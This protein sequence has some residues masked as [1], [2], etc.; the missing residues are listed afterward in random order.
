M[1]FL[2]PLGL[3][4]LLGIP[5]LIIIYI[6]K[7]KYTE[8]TIASTYLWT[9]SEKFIKKKNPISRVTGII[10]LIL[11][12]LA[13][14]LISFMVAQPIINVPNSANE[15]CF[16]L[17]GSG[18]MNME[19]GGKTRFERGQ[20]IIAGEIDASANGSLYSLVYMGDT[21]TVVY[22]KLESKEAAKELL[23]ELEPSYKFIE[24]D[25]AISIAQSF[26]NENTGIKSYFV[27]DK[28]YRTSN[29][30]IIKN[31]ARDE[32]NNAIISASYALTKDENGS[33]SSLVVTGVAKSYEGRVPLTFNVYVDGSEEIR[34]SWQ[35]LVEEKE[36]PFTVVCEGISSVTS[37][38]VRVSEYDNLISD[39]SYVIFNQKSEV[40]YSTLIVSDN[41]FYIRAAIEALYDMT[42]NVVS[43]DEYENMYNDKLPTGYGLYI[44][45]SYNVRELPRD[46]AVWLF[47]LDSAPQG[48]GFS[49]QGKVELA[50]G[51]ALDMSKSSASTIK[52]LT[53]GVIG[54]DLYI[55]REFMKYGV[56]RSSHTLFS[57]KGNPIVFAGVN[58][59]GN[60]QVVF[61]FDYH[62]SNFP[63]KPGDYLMLNKN[64]IDYSFPEI[65]DKSGYRCGES[66]E[67]NVLANCDSIRIDSPN[68][69]V[70][71]LD[72]GSATASLE[73]TEVG[74]YTIT[75]QIG[76][77]KRVVNIFSSMDERESVPK[78]LENEVS[79]NGQASS[80][81][82]DGKFD[83]IIILFILLAIVF[84]A[85]W[86]VYC[87]ERCQLR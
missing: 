86:M 73:L 5:I 33:G 56:Y 59:Y 31:V 10:S 53:S 24:A 40:A 34:G 19:T 66:V 20:D 26:F 60:R 9:L 68:E 42:I 52:K 84:L 8:Q 11:Q 77:T 71:Y 72:T 32:K 81:G 75:M 39:N 46:G 65:I 27:T 57:Y 12:I 16:V 18:S 29:N 30:I 54:N 85:D 7:S 83:P 15:Y 38:E 4:G 55:A 80:G 2:F 64:L 51:V 43:V 17:D 44:Y 13:I 79:L 25:E 50:T 76:S 48:S 74:V 78:V 70:S 58:D 69:K 67:I 61:A 3:L 82:F 1:T 41:P 37:V 22:N 63:G 35:G 47:N 87:Y 23:Y 21:T 6:I 62:N 14:A 36:T 28:L 45:D 49:F